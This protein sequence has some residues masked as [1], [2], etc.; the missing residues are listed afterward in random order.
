MENQGKKLNKKLLMIIG[1][2]VAAVAVVAV[3]LVLALGGK[4]GS[5]S[6]SDGCSHEW[7]EVSRVPGRT[8]TEDGFAE[9]VCELCEEEKT[10]TIEAPGHNVM[11]E[12][13][14]AST[15]TVDGVSDHEY[16]NVCGV[17]IKAAEYIPAP[18][19]VIVTDEA[20]EPNCTETGLTEGSH[21]STCNIVLVEQNTV[22]EKGH[23]NVLDR[24]YAATCLEDG[25]SNGYH[26][27]VCSTVTTPQTV[28]GA[29]G[30]K[31][32]TVYGSEP[33]CA[34][35]GLTDGT[36]CSRCEDMIVPQ[37]VIPAPGHDYAISQFLDPTCE[38]DG[39]T[40]GR[41]CKECNIVFEVE[42]VIPKTVH[43]YVS[44]TCKWCNLTASSGLTFDE[45]ADGEY[46]VL[47]GLGSCTDTEIVV[48]NTYGGKPVKAMRASTFKGN[49][50]V[51]KVTLPD[52]LEAVEATSFE[53]CSALKEVYLPESITS[54]GANA[55]NNCAL[56]EK[57]ECEDYMQVNGWS[58]D[59]FGNTENKL[60]SEYR[61]GKTPYEV[62][63]EAMAALGQQA[64]SYKSTY[65]NKMTA[66]QLNGSNKQTIA[67]QAVYT[68]LVGMDM[69]MEYAPGASMGGGIEMNSFWYKGGVYY[70]KCT[71]PI[72]GYSYIRREVSSD[73][74]RALAAD[75]QTSIPAPNEETFKAA[76]FVR[77]S[78][79]TYTL[80]L[81]LDEDQIE[82]MVM[83][84]LE[85]MFG[86]NKDTYADIITFT[87]CV[88]KYD[89]DKNGNIAHTYVD[90][91][92]LVDDLYGQG[93]DGIFTVDGDI[94]YSEVGTINALTLPTPTYYYA[95][96]IS[97]SHY[98]GYHVTVPGYAATCTTDGLT[99]G[100]YCSNCM[101]S[102][103][104]SQPIYRHGHSTEQGICDDCGVFVGK[105]TNFDVRYNDDGKTAVLVGLGDVSGRYIEIPNSIYGIKIIEIADGVFAGLTDLEDVYIPD[106]VQKIGKR[107]FE[108]CTSLVDITLPKSL[109]TLGDGAFKGCSSLER[110]FISGKNVIEEIGASAFEGCASLR[111]FFIAST[112]ETIGENAFLGCNPDM[113]INVEKYNAPAGWDTSWKPESIEATFG[114]VPATDGLAYDVRTEWDSTNSVYVDYYVIVGYYGTEKDIIIRGDY[115]G[116]PVKSINDLAFEN[117][118]ITSVTIYDGITSI[119]SKTFENCTKLESLV[120]PSTLT[121]I[122]QN[123]FRGCT[124][125]AEV[126]LPESLTEIGAYAFYNTGIS[127]ITIGVNVKTIGS[128]AFSG[129]TK[130]ESVKFNAS[131]LT[132]TYSVFNSCSADL[133]TF[134]VLVGNKV[135]Y[136]PQSLFY[137]SNISAIEFEAGSVCTAIKADAFAYS[138]NLASISIPDTIVTFENGAFTYINESA[139]TYENG[140]AYIGNADNPYRV[141]I[142]TDGSAITELKFNEKTEIIAVHFGSGITRIEIGENVNYI[143]AN[144]FK[145]CKDVTEIVYNA[146]NATLGD[147]AFSDSGS[148]SYVGYDS[149]VKLIIGSKVEKIP[150]KM[151]YY[152]KS[153]TEIVFEE[154]SSLTEIG[155]LS[156]YYC[157][158]LKTLVLP[159]SL[160]TIEK[161]AFNCCS[162][163][164]SVTLGT[165]LETIGSSAF[166]NCS[167]LYE[168]VNNSSIDIKNA[169]N[170]NVGDIK[171]NAIVITTGKSG[172]MELADCTFI[173]IPEYMNG[174]TPVAASY[175]LLKY[176]GAGGDVVLPDN[177]KGLGYTIRGDAFSSTDITSIVISDGATSISSRAFSSC[178][179]LKTVVIGKNVTFIDSSA[180]EYCSALT[181]VSIADGD[182]PLVFYAT[183]FR[184]CNNI[185]TFKMPGRVSN[186]HKVSLINGTA[187]N[188]F[189]GMTKLEFKEYGNLKYLGTDSNPYAFVYSAV[190]NN[191]T[192]ITFHEGTRF[193]NRDALGYLTNLST[194]VFSAK[195]M[196]DILNNDFNLFANA[197]N[198]SGIS[199]TI[200]SN[201][202][203]IPSY[204]F[205]VENITSIT[206][207]PKSVCEYLGYNAFAGTKIESIVLPD[208]ITE[209]GGSVFSY[210]AS[211]TSV[212]IPSKM[213]Y[214]PSSFANGC[215]NLKSVIV[216][217]EVTKI[218]GFAFN[219]CMSLE[220][221]VIPSTVTEFGS[222]CFDGCKTSMS[223][224]YG[225]TSSQYG[226]ITFGSSINSKITIY[227]N[228]QWTMENGV[229]K[230]K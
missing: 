95:S 70:I 41:Y 197:G 178:T 145:S 16:C 200:S 152:A 139:C 78:D 130:F 174:T 29:L 92:M 121:F 222:Y 26:C 110:V 190:D 134:T 69:Y 6:D 230:R 40:S 79:G 171:R 2:S 38:S 118:K 179:K 123:A 221:I 229:P 172:L 116:L 83:D 225:G 57:V 165:S 126:S 159:D 3:V 66:E 213:K 209:M 30:H 36:Y 151:F 158:A 55:F 14:H 34:E 155:E 74:I 28:I 53:G 68:E 144:A 173:Y 124:A 184:G 183:A 203:R 140:L 65:T 148:Y 7:L 93:I 18:G 129:C 132:S 127:E 204:L 102:I 177:I 44:N 15:C 49:T 194:I 228:D 73:Y 17:T 80:T 133:P 160:V 12:K 223:V 61:D 136:I 115:M 84:L 146:K 54:V 81:V 138:S 88:Y 154:G 109:V 212:N 45:S 1:G 211:L 91:K 192:S 32:N 199:L 87:E 94:I 39:H 35:D 96:D 58:A 198:S 89:F 63:L 4:G 147:T 227:Y 47:T 9:Y 191:V 215:R 185:T 43:S 42:N 122:A 189:D 75:L 86:E 13:G 50:T 164:L 166:M 59:C 167:R 108:G 214:I 141:C 224:Y 161:S 149:S 64:N 169:S 119:G 97:C 11:V 163:L 113:V 106:S 46:Y 125:L 157:S 21:C 60:T 100:V 156:F 31:E 170:N 90:S 186:I 85:M 105:V 10:E 207:E 195:E 187:S 175:A 117:A 142:S 52:T 5:G 181:S 153:I 71:P 111:S 104:Q 112:V 202:K 33:S 131:A 180:F 27:N 135:E 19:H 82:L 20:V 201:V 208:T 8:C 62:Y 206:F 101:R 77:N 168:V 188:M 193:I 37:T 162:N 219:G 99:D 23:T 67:N 226:G 128:Y 120:L 176:N 143:C 220:W 24:G 182:A 72:N 107:A 48:P 25:L 205:S 103:T 56:L 137:Q 210:C 196:N 22:R 98:S 76:E 216:P 51:V 150:N 217:D 114:Y 218:E